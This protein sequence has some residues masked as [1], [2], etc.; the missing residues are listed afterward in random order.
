M[1]T[2]TE[3]PAWLALLT[4]LIERMGV[5]KLAA[6]LSVSR[7]TVSAWARRKHSPNIR[8]VERMQAIVNADSPCAN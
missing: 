5:V 6:A 4:S 2:T 8:Y 3:A 7:Q 1:T